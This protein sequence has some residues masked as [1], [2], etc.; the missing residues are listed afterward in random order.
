ML[1][2]VIIITLGVVAVCVLGYRIIDGISDKNT[3]AQQKKDWNKAPVGKEVYCDA[4]KD[5]FAQ[6]T[7]FETRGKFQVCPKCGAKAARAIVYFVCGRP[8]CDET[9]IKV[10]NHVFEGSKFHKSPDRLECP[11][12]ERNEFIE[13]QVLHLETAEEIAKRTGQE[14]E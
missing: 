2:K 9:L 4:C 12:C 1:V 10:A 5:D 8:E 13:P 3:I 6:V 11:T 14:I 7:P